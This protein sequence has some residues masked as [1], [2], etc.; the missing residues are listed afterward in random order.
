MDWALTAF[1]KPVNKYVAK[2]N[3]NTNVLLFMFLYQ[4]G[5]AYRPFTQ[6]YKK[7]NSSI[8]LAQLLS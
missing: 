2:P 3:N 7:N 8:Y 5:S 4:T 1:P 6:R